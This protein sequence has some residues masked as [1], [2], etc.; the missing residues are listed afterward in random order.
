M[1][2]PSETLLT[3]G[4][5]PI[6]GQREDLSDVVSFI[7]PEE[8]P[9][10]MWCGSGT[11]TSIT[12]EWMKINLRSPAKNAKAEGDQ[13]AATAPKRGTRL[14]NVAQIGTEVAVVSGTAE[15]VDVA[16]NLGDLEEQLIYKSIELRRDVE[17]GHLLANQ[18][19]SATD[20]R[21]CAGIVTYA[22]TAFVGAGGTLPTADGDTAYVAG[23]EWVLGTEQLNNHHKEM[24][25]LGARPAMMMMHPSAKLVFDHLAVAENLADGQVALDRAGGGDMPFYVTVGVYKNAFGTVK[26]MLNQWMGE[27]EILTFDDRQQFRP[28]VCPLPGRDFVKGVT[29]F[30]SDGR[31]QAVIFEGCLEVPN[32]AAVGLLAG[33]SINVPS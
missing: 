14:K 12:H 29:Q 18:D 30:N 4:G 32:P 15:A 11:A 2:V 33:F 19:W 3:T 25:L 28:K 22:D 8:V 9:F 24:Y 21:E 16:G 27:A 23:T 6:I 10:Y 7:D 5:S 31:S 17:A 1:T 13:F 20:P 26:V